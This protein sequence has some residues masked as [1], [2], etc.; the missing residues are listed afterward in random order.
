MASD[1]DQPEYQAPE[2][3]EELEVPKNA[4]ATIARLWEAMVGLR[5][6]IVACTV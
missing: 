4:L 3:A 2:P 6:R 1:N 5:W